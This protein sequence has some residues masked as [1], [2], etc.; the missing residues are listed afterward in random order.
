VTGDAIAR[1]TARSA[2]MARWAVSALF[3]HLGLCIGTWAPHIPFAKQRLLA[4]PT[5]FGLALLFVG[6]GGV[7]AM[8]AMG[9]VI[10]RFGSAHAAVVAA[11]LTLA[12]LPLPV[13]APD[14]W[15]FA[16][17]LL[18]F[19]ASYGSLDVAINAHGLLVETTLRRPVMSAFHGLYS[20]AGLAGAGLAAVM[21]E[22][23]SEL[24][25]VLVSSAICLALTR[26]AAHNLLPAGA[27]RGKSR[28]PFA[29]PTRATIGMG[30][31]CLLALLIEGAIID[32]CGINLREARGA[33]GTI[34]SL[35]FGLFAGGMALSRMVGDRARL[36]WGSAFV[37]RYTALSTAILVMIAVT[38]PDARLS[39]MAF[40]LSGVTIG[41]LAPILFAGGGR[42]DPDNPGRSIA[43]VTTLGYSGFV[44][45]P[46]IVGILADWSSVGVALAIAA[47][48]G[49]VIAAF[50]SAA[51]VADGHG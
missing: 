12:T 35:A 25:R 34:T 9:L 24:S 11:L 45:G 43:A 30:L 32:W 14:L 33:S 2:E 21:I 3:F 31:L 17:A 46:A 51:R 20:L 6:L 23:V 29:L 28:T 4:S 50:S 38:V 42:A 39:L 13:I 5:G 15:T 1:T 8:P 16:L 10:N 48:T 47:A 7:I 40:A 44:L 49:F 27:D 41:P 37:V 22:H 19:G 26:F 36:R 18:V